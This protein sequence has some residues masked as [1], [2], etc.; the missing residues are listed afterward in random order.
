MCGKIL[1]TRQTRVLFL[2]TSNEAQTDMYVHTT[3]HVDDFTEVNQL[4]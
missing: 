1:S 4:A 2:E 3:N